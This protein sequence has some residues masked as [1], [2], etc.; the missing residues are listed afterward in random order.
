MNLVR[1]SYL[2]QLG[3]HPD[4]ED[5][6]FQLVAKTSPSLDHSV[7]CLDKSVLIDCA[8]LHFL[9]NYLTIV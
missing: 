5:E 7:F 9:T 3:H 8:W 2:T 6:A 1:T 4:W